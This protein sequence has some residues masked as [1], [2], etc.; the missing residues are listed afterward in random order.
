MLESDKSL[1]TN[2]GKQSKSRR[3]K[4]FN[5]THIPNHGLV[6]L[7]L[8]IKVIRGNI[9]NFSPLKTKYTRTAQIHMPKIT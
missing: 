2:D 5:K 8:T 9:A 3:Y 1:I 4:S 6:N 7:I